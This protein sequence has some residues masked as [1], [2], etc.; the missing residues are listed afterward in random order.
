MKPDSSVPH[1]PLLLDQV[2]DVIRGKHYN[3]RTE[4]AYLYWVRLYMRWQGGA[5]S[6]PS[7]S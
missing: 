2:C 4:Q 5:K 7:H 3:A 1:T 6:K